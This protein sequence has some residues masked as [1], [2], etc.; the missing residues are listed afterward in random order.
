[1]TQVRRFV[2]M[3]ALVTSAGNAYGQEPSGLNGHIRGQVV[4]ARTAAP[5]AAVLVQ[6]ESSRQRTL[7]DGDGRFV[8]ENVPS[9]TQIVMVSVVGFGLVR[10]EVLV[11]EGQTSE[12]TI[13]VAEGASTYVEE[14]TVTA[15]RFQEA[16]P[17]AASQAVL[18][19]RELLALRGVIADDPFRAVQV[20]PGVA[21]GDDYRAEFAVRGLGPS[22]VGLAI[23]DVDSRLLFH[24]VR[25][26]TD[27]G[28]LALIN[29]DILEQATLLSGVHPQKL[30]SH[31]GAR[32]DFRTRD[33]A[34]DRLHGRVLVSGSATT[35]VW[36]GPFGDGSRGSWLVAG[37]KSYIDWLLRRVDTAIEGSFGFT[38]A[39]AKVSLTPTPRQ[40][41]RLS[42]IGGHSQL[43]EDPEGGLNA[44]DRGR[45]HTLIG[46][47]QWRFT[48]SPKWALSQ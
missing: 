24:T 19:S 25:G 1:V 43:D 40:T 14:V 42:F 35:S 27:T 5:L 21:A 22:H 11:V 28:S 23:D 12:L 4:E 2:F 46:N 13:P 9:G 37:R 30:G 36:E 48:P 3:L 7:S 20:L 29:S 34:R 10:R 44:F 32:L 33:G 38:D 18:G 39:Q 8:L 26:I 17:G 47:A 6:V 41:L 16:Q 15:T 31:L 45:N